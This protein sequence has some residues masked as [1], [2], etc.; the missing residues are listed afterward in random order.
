MTITISL[1]YSIARWIGRGVIKMCMPLHGLGAEIGSLQ[2][3]LS[4]QRWWSWFDFRSP[5]TAIPTSLVM[6]VEPFLTPS[7]VADLFGPCT[8]KL[9]PPRASRRDGRRSGALLYAAGPVLSPR[10]RPSGPLPVAPGTGFGRSASTP[11]PSARICPVLG[12][13]SYLAKSVNGGSVFWQ[14]TVHGGL[15]QTRT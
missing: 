15:I 4:H 13:L 14:K 11:D 9:A 12:D 10:R 8:S 2:V 5:L 6:S 1:T 7:F 3:E